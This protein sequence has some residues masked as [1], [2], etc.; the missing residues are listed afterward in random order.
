MV[1]NAKL[2]NNK[3]GFAIL[4]LTNMINTIDNSDAMILEIVIIRDGVDEFLANI[5]MLNVNYTKKQTIIIIFVMR[6]IFL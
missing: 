6:P 1:R 5:M 3:P 2:L 4:K